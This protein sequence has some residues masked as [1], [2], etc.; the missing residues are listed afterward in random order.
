MRNDEYNSS[1]TVTAMEGG[2]ER[3]TKGKS[4]NSCYMQE[5]C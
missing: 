3:Q 5:D 1:S 2:A 4:S